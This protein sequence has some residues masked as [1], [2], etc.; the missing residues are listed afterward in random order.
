MIASLIAASVSLVGIAAISAMGARVHRLSGSVSA[1]ASGFLVVAVLFHLFPHALEHNMDA[2]IWAI[3]AFAAMAATG[4]IIQNLFANHPDQPSLTMGYVSIVA[5]SFHSLLDGGVYAASFE[6]HLFTGIVS[7]AAL[8]LHEFPEA[9]IAFLF[10]RNAGYESLPSAIG[11]FIAAGL[12]TVV[13]A[14]IG[15]WAIAAFFATPPLGA[16]YGAAAGALTYVV[17]F[18]LIPHAIRTSSRHGTIAASIGVS[19]GTLVIILEVISGG[20]A[21]H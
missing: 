13:G 12:S 18:H 9:I 5:L 16:L 19:I 10:L 11:A 2:W 21:G 20:H 3:G 6:E 8:M 14:A 17:L 1:L 7:V 15:T 4:V